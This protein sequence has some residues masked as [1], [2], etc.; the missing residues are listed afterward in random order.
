MIFLGNDW[1]EDHHDV[2]LCNE[3]GERLAAARL[4]HGIEGLADLH[5]LLARHA[6]DPSQ[7]V[8][9][10]E[11]DRGL[12]V[13]GLL[14]AGYT[15][16]AINP[17]A[18]SRYRDRHTLSGA[19]SDAADAKLLAEIVRIDRHNH[20]V[21]AG[22]S[23]LAEAVRVL[24]R[25]HQTLI[26]D[27]TRHTN[28]LRDTLLAFYPAAVTT[29]DDLSHPDALAVLRLAPD[30]DRG[31]ALQKRQILAA[32]RRAG[33]KRHLDR[34]VEA[35]AAGLRTDQLSAPLPI[36]A[37]H[38]RTVRATVAVLTALTAEIAEL[39]ADLLDHFDQ[40]PDAVIYRSLPGLGV[41]LGARVLSEF[42]DDPNRYPTA[43]SRKNYAGTS[44]ITKASGRSEVVL[45]RFVR[46]RRLAD[47]L[48]MWAFCALSHSPG[49]RAL[50]DHRRER[51]DSHHKALRA[52]ANRLVGILHGCLAHHTPYDE[53]TAWAHRLTTNDTTTPKLAA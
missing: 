23:D 31:R 40:H 3:Q 2:Y 48:H 26:W 33:R 21:V 1:A 28:R 35:I 49:A 12:W 6:H 9:G 16:Y 5:A 14:A 44:P 43:K 18:A 32:L 19:K 7:V 13:T 50:Y 30:P 17:R 15:V 46:N 25:A 20:R 11:T 8:V 51:G 27:R 37:A 22:D 47:A 39:Q 52:L 24:A 45:A 4:P 42:G 34:R 53:N 41:V 36:A 38:A 29:F 10:I